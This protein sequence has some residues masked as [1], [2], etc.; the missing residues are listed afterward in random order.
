MSERVF[1][2]TPKGFLIAK[3]ESLGL[4][5][6]DGDELWLQLEAFCVRQVRTDFP[7]ATWA[8]IAF[9]GHGGTAIPL[10][11]DE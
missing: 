7:D 3:I 2:L 10:E 1:R 4:S 11:K 8:G 9:D 5:K 6:D